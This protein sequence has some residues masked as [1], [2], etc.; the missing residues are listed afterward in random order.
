[1]PSRVITATVTSGSNVDKK[2][3]AYVTFGSITSD[4]GPV[5]DC[6]PTSA[7][8]Y[9]SK[10]KTYAASFYLD[11]IYGGNSGI[12][13]ASTET[14]DSNS[15]NHSSTESIDYLTE[16]SL[17]ES[18]ST[19]TL[20]V[21]STSG[22][23]N[24][25][26]I[27]DGCTLTL[28]INYENKY[29]PC[30][31]PTSVSLASTTVDAG[32]ST[33]LSW[34]G[35]TAGKN[36][37]IR[38]YVIYRSTSASS[39]YT[40]L[41]TTTNTSYSVTAPSTMGS[42]YYYK[43][44]TLDTI[45]GSQYLSTVY[46]TLT[47]RTY[48]AC[49]APTT[50]SVSAT[51]V[52][53]GASVTLSWSGAAVGTNN[54]ITGYQVYRATSA[55]GT[56]SLLANVT[57]TATSGSTT[58][59]AP[60]SSGSSYY[61]KVL[62]VGAKSGYSSGQ[63]SKYAT[64]TCTFTA[65]SA[66]STVTIGGGTSAY[67]LSG[68]NVTLA[69]SG[70]AAG[71]NNAITGYAIYRDG[72]VYVEKVAATTPSCSV[73]A[74]STAGSSYAYT[75][76]TLGTHSNST[77]STARTVYTYS[78]PT[79]PTSVSVSNSTPDAGESVL[80]SWSGATAGSHNAISGYHIHRAASADGP[81]E[82]IMTV[83]ST[84][85][86]SAFNVPAP[87]DMG[88]SYY[89]KVETAAPRG[90]SG[91]STQYA[92]VTAK[93]YTACA[94]PTLVT[95]SSELVIPGA[96]VTLSWT[97]G[98]SGTN[99][100]L[101]GHAVYRK[102]GA[103]AYE[104]LQTVA[105]ATTSLSVAAPLTPGSSYTYY[106]VAL[107]TKTGYDS[108]ASNTVTLSSYAYTA[109]TAPTSLTLSA[110]LAEDGAVLSWSGAAAGVS[111]PITGYRI[112]AQNSTSG[113]TWGEATLLQTVTTSATSGSVSVEPPAIRG[114]YRRFIIQTL[115]TASGFDSPEAVYPTLLRKNRAP[116]APV[117]LSGSETYV[118]NP[119][120]RLR[121]GDEPDGQSQ[122]LML[123]VDDGTAE[124]VAAES[125]LQDLAFGEHIIRAYSLDS[126]GAASP[127]AAHTLTVIDSGF[128]D[129]VL[130][131][132]QTFVKAVHINELRARI[133]T[134][135]AYYGLSAYGWS[136]APVAGETGLVSWRDHV[137]EL[138]SALADAYASVG[139]AVPAWTDLP[140]NCPKAIAIDE[141]REAVQAI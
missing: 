6:E 140:V 50:V 19:I 100:E 94:A 108:A 101:S 20:G 58:V 90:C 107:G 85:T 81:Y 18:V 136:A 44:A 47:A 22:T 48:T 114:A 73:P 53:P 49:T 51:G 109:C 87:D 78:L 122:T 128:T 124:A 112:S 115:G 119:L 75:V 93:T 106:V 117:F 129:P 127:V 97:A 111:N 33:T 31:A 68:T 1:M 76:V 105:S 24:K 123:S 60:T 41:T 103:G 139:V 96:S 10:Y 46:A 110:E 42:K 134:L 7:T 52:A 118:H 125:R 30:T 16:D 45:D 138:R 84:A 79:A 17:T 2:G 62:T 32:A 141:L 14:L 98:S 137:L 92:V 57:S 11:V 133:N 88:E 70:A 8:L 82:E 36:N 132:G 39:G 86:S 77:A 34:S 3:G 38:G 80:L 61:Y 72:A 56:Y 69:W 126:M 104:L 121:Y 25:I 4:T 120:I 35:A 9:L 27:R 95:L 64:L 113:T 15:T 13:V 26:N 74:H 116:G 5:W 130:T 71:T 102:E 89:Y 28:T 54:A 55:T 43:V 99:N 131:A 12:V 63:S 59:T 66:P 37:P 40:E 83:L 67:A 91:L 135:R 23:G 21:V 29:G 65:P